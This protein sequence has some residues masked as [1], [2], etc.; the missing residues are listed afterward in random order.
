MSLWDTA[1]HKKAYQANA[2]TQWTGTITCIHHVQEKKYA[3]MF[4][5]YILQNLV[6]FDK[7]W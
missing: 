1:L 7:I 5:S 2:T 4:L 3:K 6:D